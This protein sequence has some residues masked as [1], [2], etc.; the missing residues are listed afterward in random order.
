MHGPALVQAAGSWSLHAC[1]AVHG[2]D[3]GTD[4]PYAFCIDHA[5]SSD[6]LFGLGPGPPQQFERTG[7]D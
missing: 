1:C 7:A 6:W 5:S 3:C 4:G 2:N